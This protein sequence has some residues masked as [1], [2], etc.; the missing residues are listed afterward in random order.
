VA[1]HRS[2]SRPGGGAGSA[3]TG[4]RRPMGRPARAALSSEAE[5][6][7][8]PRDPQALADYLVRLLDGFAQT[9]SPE[10]DRV[11]SAIIRVAL[12]YNDAKARGEDPEAIRTATIVRLVALEAELA[13]FLLRSTRKMRDRLVA[14]SRRL[15]TG[16]P[17][18]QSVR[19]AAE[20]LTLLVDALT[21]MLE[22]AEEHDP[23]KRRH[24]QALLDKARVAMASLASP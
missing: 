13:Q 2:G 14:D 21:A 11:R 22:A 18:A 23:A 10:A 8:A 1:T 16:S 12:D 7:A 3:A 19:R 24:A 15:G 9:G 4:S 6:G 17:V 5:P 20:G